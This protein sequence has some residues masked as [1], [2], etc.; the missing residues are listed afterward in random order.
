MDTPTEG[1]ESA[2]GEVPDAPPVPKGVQQDPSTG[3]T[4]VVLSS[5]EAV[6]HT[7]GED[8]VLT[9]QST[10]AGA[11]SQAP[12]EDGVA[13]EAETEAS[14]EAP[15]EDAT[16]LSVINPAV[17]EVITEGEVTLVESTFTENGGMAMEIA[18]S[19]D[20]PDAPKTEVSI[21]A[22]GTQQ[23]ITSP[24][25]ETA[26][27][28]TSATEVVIAMDEGS[29]HTSLENMEPGDEHPMVATD[30]SS[31]VASTGAD[32]EMGFL[33]ADGLPATKEDGTEYTAEDMAAMVVAFDEE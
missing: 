24:T 25:G 3:Q 15:D 11:S 18:S 30:G 22:D 10:A 29:M 13:D 33:D 21:S 2:E 26:T 1:Q 4:T 17:G 14:S 31:V 16:R 9:M 7:M 19:G 27:A 28:T 32:G 6:G 23:A 20:E 8:G 12:N 5:G